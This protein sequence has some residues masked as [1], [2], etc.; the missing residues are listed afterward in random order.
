MTPVKFDGYDVVLGAPPDWDEVQHGPCIGLPVMRGP[1]TCTSVWKPT[2]AE[3]LRILFGGN[4]QL[5]VA[6]GGT[7]P[8]VALGVHP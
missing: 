2:I 1:E 3:R 6:A 8:P 7:Q 4:I 5:T